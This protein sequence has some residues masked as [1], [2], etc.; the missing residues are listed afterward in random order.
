MFIINKKTCNINRIIFFRGT[1]K[2]WNNPRMGTS[3]NPNGRFDTEIY[4]GI[5][6]TFSQFCKIPVATELYPIG[7]FLNTYFKTGGGGM[8]GKSIIACE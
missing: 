1:D 2:R 4:P 7:T 5:K 3:N 8:G 6:K